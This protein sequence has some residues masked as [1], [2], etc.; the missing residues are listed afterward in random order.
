MWYRLDVRRGSSGLDEGL[1]AE[2]GFLFL[3]CYVHWRCDSGGWSEVDGFSEGG[4]KVCFP[5]G[6][7]HRLLEEEEEEDEEVDEEVDEDGWKGKQISFQ[8]GCDFLNFFFTNFILHIIGL[9]CHERHMIQCGRCVCV[10][11]EILQYE[12]WVSS[13]L[14]TLQIYVNVR[15]ILLH[16]GAGLGVCVRACISNVVGT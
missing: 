6:L 15:N 11:L 9:L 8:S 3:L 4:G 10:S 2:H 1:D 14:P 13:Y 7:R 5:E 12:Y 16:F